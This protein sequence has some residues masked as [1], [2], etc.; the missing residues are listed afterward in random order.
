MIYLRAFFHPQFNLRLSVNR[1]KRVDGLK[2]SFWGKNI[3]DNEIQF[4]ELT[5]IK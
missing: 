1:K 5:Y 4:L 2:M 3:K